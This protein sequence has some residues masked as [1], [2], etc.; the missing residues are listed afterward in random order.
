[1]VFLSDVIH[2]LEQMKKADAVKAAGVEQEADHLTE[3]TNEVFDFDD[4]TPAV[5]RSRD[6]S[7]RPRDDDQQESVHVKRTKH[8]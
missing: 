4:A 8:V 2:A 1:M 5:K 6:G 7:K 3:E